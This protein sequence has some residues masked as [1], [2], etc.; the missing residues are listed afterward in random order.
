MSRIEWCANSC[1]TEPCHFEFV[2][3]ILLSCLF[4]FSI[5]LNVTWNISGLSYKLARSNTIAKVALVDFVPFFTELFK[6]TLITFLSMLKLSTICKD[7]SKNKLI[8]SYLLFFVG[9]QILV[10]LWVSL[11]YLIMSNLYAFFFHERPFECRQA[12]LIK[13]NKVK[14]SQN[15]AF[16]GFSLFRKSLGHGDNDCMGAH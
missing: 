6:S 11:S 13:N 1:M 15:E 8:F 10:F 3:Q 12:F 2:Q 7:R 9:F 5:I 16:F 4:T 14:K